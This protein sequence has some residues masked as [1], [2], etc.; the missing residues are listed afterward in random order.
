MYLRHATP[1]QVKQTEINV[2]LLNSNGN[3]L[4]LLKMNQKHR[5]AIDSCCEDIVPR[6]NVV[7]LWPK[8]LENKVF[9]RDDVNVPRWK[10]KMLTYVIFTRNDC[11]E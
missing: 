6:I 1:R 7:K 9:N 4:I 5:D 8:L 10:V 3:F 2:H 11:V